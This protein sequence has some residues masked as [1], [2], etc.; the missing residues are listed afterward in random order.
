[1]NYTASV[2][3]LSRFTSLCITFI[4]SH[5]TLDPLENN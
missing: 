3:N 1:V 2:R 5:S 4:N